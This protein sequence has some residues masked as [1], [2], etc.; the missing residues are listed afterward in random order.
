MAYVRTIWLV[1]L[2]LQAFCLGAAAAG[3]KPAD[4]AFRLTV[5]LGEELGLE[6]SW[7][8]E[9]GYY[10]YRDRI[11][12]RLGDRPL[13][14][15]TAKG[16]TKDDPTFGPTEVYHRQAIAYVDEAMP[17][18]GELHVTYQGCGENTI[19][20]PPVTKVID[21]ATLTVRDAGEPPGNVHSQ[22]A[23]ES[24][25]TTASATGG[26][27]AGPDLGGSLASTLLAFLGFGVLLAFTPCVF[28]MLPILAG[29]L[30]RS[31]G[32][33]STGRGFLLSAAYV[34]A[35][36][37]AYGVL[38][39]FA[40]WFGGNL[41][42]YLQT[43]LAVA[44]MSLAFA[45]LALSMFGVYELQMP[46]SL[47]ARWMPSADRAG[48]LGGAALLGLASALIVGP[49]VTPPLAAALIYIA[50]TGDA[51]RGSAA[52]S[53][54]GLGMGL[55]LLAFG[56]LGA[57]VLPRS[58]PWLVRVKQAFGIVFLGI[59]VWMLS[60]IL[61]LSLIAIAWGVLFVGIAIWAGEQA[62][63]RARSNLRW[64]RIASASGAIALLFYG[65]L[66]AMGGLG[67]WYA[68]LRPLAWAGIAP[69]IAGAGNAAED[70][71]V[72]SNEADLDAALAAGGADGR[73]VMIDFSAEWCTECRLM[74][75]SVLAD[76]TVRQ[77]LGR[78]RL[79]RADMTRFDRSSKRLMERF[80]VIGPPTLI[81]LNAAGKEIEGTRIVG[82]TVVD[83]ILSKVAAAERG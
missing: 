69:S 31:A 62:L 47:A 48:S 17:E 18:T 51:L 29:M 39:I 76:E 32:T 81:F 10:L 73:P 27:S 6:L 9:P 55:P 21:L 57:K 40:A 67:G 33:L 41:Q 25:L 8:I 77:R 5:A 56:T 75:R 2:L 78:L 30:S 54:L 66:L 58:G 43:P 82:M 83:D 22:P 19:C 28:P 1:T 79:I 50:Q 35:M 70:F 7:S 52:L 74:E 3:P 36:A 64:W 60:R 61:P 46:Q 16:E 45:M 80:A 42:L 63:G 15:T 11:A 65:G 13:K 34:L 20:Y 4:Q 49:C 37:G 14:V 53:A 24:A 44:L 72:V 12:A 59:A 71:Q 23:T 68:P 38:G 26:E